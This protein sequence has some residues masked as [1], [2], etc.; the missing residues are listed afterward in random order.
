M[1][2][3][4]FVVF[5]LALVLSIQ[6]VVGQ[7]EKALDE[8][9]S[10]GAEDVLLSSEVAKLLENFKSFA[11]DD[12]Q[13]VD[14]PPSGLVDEIAASPELEVEVATESIGGRKRKMA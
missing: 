1:V 13:S 9:A 10:P 6:F 12:S 5:S 14:G 3:V 4:P 11:G 2:K 8:A 7:D